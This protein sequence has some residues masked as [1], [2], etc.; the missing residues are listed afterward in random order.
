M[1]LENFLAFHQD[2][3]LAL[4]GKNVHP[5]NVIDIP[6]DYLTQERHI[7]SARKLT[8]TARDKRTTMLAPLVGSVIKIPGEVTKSSLGH[9]YEKFVTKSVNCSI[10]DFTKA[11]SKYLLLSEILAFTDWHEDM[12]SSAV[13]YI[14]LTGNY[15]PRFLK[16]LFH[17][18]VV[19]YCSN[20]CF[21]AFFYVVFFCML[22]VMLYVLLFRR[23]DFSCAS[24]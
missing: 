14:L 6:L 3:E 12:T 17:F 22:Y 4:E 7:K 20:V 19:F 5:M 1:T 24:S 13:F 23:K 10:L 8:D 11:H 21:F 2:A 15:I 18:I 16:H 9:L